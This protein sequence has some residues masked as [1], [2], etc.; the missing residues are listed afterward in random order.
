MPPDFNT[1]FVVEALVRAGLLTQEQGQEVAIKEGAARARVLKTATEGNPSTRYDV[2]PVEIVAAFQIP[3]S[4]RG[5][6]L[7][8]DR[9]TS[10][11]AGMAGIPYRKID[12]LKL[13][14][15]LA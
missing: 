1:A 2:S 13:D 9:I 15:A 3:I 12:P 4:E 14:M 7:D 11:V 6:L 10:A 8:Q 5:D